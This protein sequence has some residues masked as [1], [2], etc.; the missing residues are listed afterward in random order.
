V[1]LFKIS[2]SGLAG[3]SYFRHY[4]FP[5]NPCFSNNHPYS[6]ICFAG[7]ILLQVAAEGDAENTF[8]FR[9]DVFRMFAAE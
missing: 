5:R 7:G 8:A 3:I 6:R 9:L 1:Q 2:N 4:I